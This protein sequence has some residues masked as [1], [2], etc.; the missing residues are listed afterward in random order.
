MK[1]NKVCSC[2]KKELTTKNV[3]LIGKNTFNDKKLL[4]FNCDD[5]HS[6]GVLVRKVQVLSQAVSLYFNKGA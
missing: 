3:T 6:A 1:L 4:Y 5:C 2:C